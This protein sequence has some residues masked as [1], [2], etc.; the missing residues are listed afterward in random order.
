[1]VRLALASLCFA[2]ATARAGDLPRRIGMY[3]TQS[4]QTALA[5]LDSK[6]EVTVHGPIVEVVATQTFRNDTDRVT[7]ATYIFPLPA[8][9]AVSAMSIV[10]G[11]R[12]IHAAIERRADAQRRYEDAVAA[13]L[14]A[15]LL[16]QE[17]PDVFT[18]T[19]SAIPPH[20][21][22]T[23]ALRYDTTA[24]YRDGAWELA[25]PL[26]V[27]PR[28]VPGGASGRP[29][30]GGGRSPDTDRAPDASRITPGGAPGAGGKTSVGIRFA[31]PVDGV[32][33]SSHELA[34]SGQAFSFVDAKSDHDAIVRWRAPVAAS[35]WAEQDEDG[36]YAA[37][38]VANPVAA[39]RKG[40]VRCVL[41]LDRSATTRGDADL[42]EHPLVRALTDA[43]AGGDVIGVIGSDRIAP[44]RGA[45]VQHALD[46]AWPHAPARFDLT[47]VLAD[48]TWAG[49]YVLVTDGLVADDAAAIAAAVKRGVPIH[50]IGVGPA[51]NRALLVALANRTNG[52]VRFAQ[53]GDDLA[54]LARD[55]LADVASPPDRLTVSWGTLAAS[56]VVPAML[57]RAG[58]GQAT[59]VIAR[60]KKA[61]QANAR[62]HG[63]LFAIEALGKERPVDGATTSHGPL[64]RRWARM[65]LDELLAAKDANAAAAH[66]LHYGLVSPLTSMVAIGTEV[67][68]KGGVKHS[69]AVPVSVPAG[70]HWQEI[71]RELAVDMT[72][73][74]G[75]DD[76]SL[77]KEEDESPRKAPKHRALENDEKKKNRPAK[78]ERSGDDDDGDADATGSTPQRS[79]VA[80]AAPVA[81]R[82]IDY[83]SGGEAVSETSIVSSERRLRISVGLAAGAAFHGTP[84]Y[85]L[86]TTDTLV[87]LST[88]LETGRLT[89]VG[90]ELSVG[91][92]GSDHGEFRGL[93]TLARRGLAGNHLELAAGAGLEIA[94]GA[95]P[96]GALSIHVRPGWHLPARLFL[97]YDASLLYRSGTR[98][99]EQD[100]TL[101]VEWHF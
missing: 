5:M 51:P 82:D 16:D 60:V 90:G 84:S 77:H 63:E 55:V 9:A 22:V 80:P 24:S 95:G 45:D 71:R 47:H 83:A 92:H 62:A 23:V 49:P 7:E 21:M 86:S 6:L 98:A 59:L 4:G 15:G 43:L 69:V 73:Q 29:T 20:G 37:V 76:K 93:L 74:E 19:V 34:G 30:T 10:D 96:A 67:V 48:A 17:R 54:A 91:L 28:Y 97:R 36:G 56:D 72:K 25:L 8:D 38:V 101:G 68:I 99:S 18:Q 46:E 27:A 70:M 79:S 31:D 89:L 32:S 33:S 41:V 94:N 64:A 53:P 50:A 61:Q 42:V 100:L 65:R 39:A 44:G 58:V 1:M 75:K 87:S 26:V 52:T 14:N 35:G 78:V 12:T 88:R 11:A 66:A 2:A 40:N 57:P 85:Q 13:G 3:P 81:A